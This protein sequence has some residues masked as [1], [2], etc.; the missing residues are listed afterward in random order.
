MENCSYCGA[1]IENGK[2]FCTNCGRALQNAGTASVAYTAAG[3]G[4]G[5]NQQFGNNYSN[6]QQYSNQQYSNTQYTSP[7]ANPQYGTNNQYGANPEYVNQGPYSNTQYTQTNANTTQ[8]KTKAF[9]FGK[10]RKEARFNRAYA[11]NELLDDRAFYAWLGGMVLYGL[12]VNIIMC[13]LTENYALELIV[14]SDGT[15][16]LF[17]SIGYLISAI[18][19]IIISN[20]STNPVVSFIGYNMIVLPLGLLLSVIVAPY[21]A[22]FPDLVTSALVMTAVITLIMV[23][24]SLLKPELF[25]RLGPVLGIGLLA[26][27]VVS[28]VSFLFSKSYIIWDYIAAGLFSLYI[29]YDMYR[30]SQ[31]PKTKDNAIDCAIDIYLDII[32]LFLRILRIMAKASSKRH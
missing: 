12:I 22:V 26:L 2:P 21:L 4:Y 23:T 5:N 9:S 15:P 6:S 24:A 3:T 10:E 20:K 19:G 16:I 7:Y 8:K 18:A 1:P 31:Y 28:L 27:I 17:I 11:A 32:N 30:A 25:S 29:G 13:I 14:G